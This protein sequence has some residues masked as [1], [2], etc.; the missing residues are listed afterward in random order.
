MSELPSKNWEKIENPQEYGYSL[1][2][3]S[4]AEKYCRE[5]NSAAFMVVVD[6]KVLFEYGE[7]ARKFSCHSIRKSFLSALYGI[8]VKKGVIN[9]NSTLGELGI[10]DGEPSLTEIEKQ[11][12][13]S[14]LLKSRSGIYHVSNFQ[15]PTSKS[16]I[17][18]RGSHKPGSFWYYNNW[19]FNVLGTIF[20]KLTGVDIFQAYKQEIA[21]PLQMEDF[22]LED[23]HYHEADEKSTH[24]AYV[25]RV[26]ARDMARFGLLYL[27]KGKWK[28]KQIIPQSWVE[29][30]SKVYSHDEKGVG[31]GYMWWVASDGK[32]LPGIELGEGTIIAEG[33]RGHYILIIPEKNMVIVHRFNTYDL[34]EGEVTDEQ[35]SKLIQ[36]I[37]N[38]KK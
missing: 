24:L 16:K 18:E 21:D 9:L 34:K 6:G 36:I 20:N 31:Y 32:L 12:E 23:C 33:F 19:D 15:T 11:A 26:T 10:D 17:P 1:E 13:V 8:Y 38:S 35:F 22:T 28:D 3:L 14:D 7:T 4:E 29:E 25:F 2:K 30:S 27:N 5:I 37:F